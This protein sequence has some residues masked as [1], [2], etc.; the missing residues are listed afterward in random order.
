MNKNILDKSIWG[1]STWNLFHLMSYSYNPEC[2]KQYVNIIRNMPYILPCMVCSDHFRRMLFNN[3]PE[4]FCDSKENMIKYFNKLHNNVNK[5]LGK[6]IIKLEDAHKIYHDKEGNLKI[7]YQKLIIFFRLILRNCSHGTSLVKNFICKSMVLNLI[8]VF[9]CTEIKEKI[10]TN[11]IN[12]NEKNVEKKIQ[13]ILKILIDKRKEIDKD[14][15]IEETKK[16]EQQR[17][18]IIKKI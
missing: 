4:K 7:H 11:V 18:K 8:K 14:K 3:P 15:K 1:P 6:R 16:K 5:R 12:I 9:P 13:S 17:R 2:K 10:E